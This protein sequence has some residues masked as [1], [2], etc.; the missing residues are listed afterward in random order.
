MIT[1]AP[2]I[3]VSSPTYTQNDDIRIVTCYPSGKPDNYTY[4]KWQHRSKYGELIREFNGN[5][6]LRLPDAP[7]LLIYQDTGEYV[8][9]A[10]NGIKDKYNKFEQTGSGLVTVNGNALYSLFDENKLHCIDLICYAFCFFFIYDFKSFN[11]RF[12]S[13]IYSTPLNCLFLLYS[14]R[15]N[16]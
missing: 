3:T 7:E 11:K 15:T 12:F 6:T 13:L 5:K 9:I 1:D 10:S 4:H 2:D 16:K 8:C 14:Y